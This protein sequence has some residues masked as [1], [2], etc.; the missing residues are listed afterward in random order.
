MAK[1]KLYL[2]GDN[3]NW[4]S[5]HVIKWRKGIIIVSLLVAVIM[6][7]CA[8]FVKINYNMSDY[9]PENANSTKAITVMSENFNESMSNAN[10]MLSNVTLDEA[11]DYKT[12]ISEISHVENVGWIDDS[13]DIEQL[14]YLYNEDASLNESLIDPTSAETIKSFYKDGNALFQITIESGY[15]QGAVNDIYDLIGEDNAMIGSAVEQASSQN[16]AISQSIKAISILGPLIILVLIL[17][18]ESF[19]E[20]LLYLTTIGV[21]TGI[22]LGLCLIR[23]EISYVTLAVAPILQLAVSLDY[24]VFLSHSFGKYRHTESSVTNAMKLAMKDSLKAISASCLTTLFGFAALLF[25]NFKIGPDMGI[26]LVSGVVLSFVAT[27]IFLPAL[28]LVTYKL[29]DKCKHRPFLPKFNKLGSGLVKSRF[30]L[31]ALIGIMLIPSFNLQSENTFIYGSGEPAKES[32]L[33]V[34]SKKIED[35]FGKSNM[36]AILV[37]RGNEEAESKLAE[38]FENLAY[39][40]SVMSYANVIGFDVP[41]EYLPEGTADK[42]YSEDYARIILSTSLETESEESFSAVKQIKD[43][44]AQY[45]SEDETYMCGNS[46]NLYDMKECIEADN[47]RVSL[48]TLIAIALILIVEFKSLIIPL[49]L[50]LVV[51]GS[52]WITLAMSAVTGEAICY[53]G[54]L[55]VSTVMMGATIDYSILI[56]DE[57]IKN[58]KSLLPL[59]AMKKTLG[60]SIKSILVSAFTLAIAGFSLGLSSSE[61]IVRLLGLMLGKGAVVA[62]VLSITLLPAILVICDKLI[63]YLSLNMEF[64]DKKNMLKPK[65]EEKVA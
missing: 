53:I 27:M 20:P 41:M 15:E 39:V 24:A 4:I 28:I 12:R 49:I 46:V 42:F 14:K 21:A 48:I 55:V 62:F 37:P 2:K 52:I 16:L 56:S 50:V 19:I 11:L 3:M 25:M 1:V 26:S 31:L 57:Y 30:V 29:N 17:S 40:E 63:P 45:Y 54:Y 36:V 23:G 44:V 32:R 13:M 18:T 60:S 38:E 8:T 34:D 22:N 6:G 43:M 65:N 64:C 7:I 10:V 35:V 5:D 59:E 61:S 9:L 58:R 33:A 51:K 47:K